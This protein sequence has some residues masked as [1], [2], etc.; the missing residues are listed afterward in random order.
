MPGPGFTFALIIATLIGSLFHVMTGGTLRRLALYLIASWI[1]FGLGNSLGY[2]LVLPGL[3]VGG[4]NVV[5]ASLG[6][7]FALILMRV[8]VADRQRRPRSQRER[9]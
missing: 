6:S 2:T 4:L 7:V 8:F 1:G 5:A 9:A 3:D